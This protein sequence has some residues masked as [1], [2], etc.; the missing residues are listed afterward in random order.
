M[1][2]SKLISSAPIILVLSALLTACSTLGK[3]PDYEH[4]AEQDTMRLETWSQ[5]SSDTNTT[6]PNEL[7]VSPVL[8]SIL[9]QAM[10][11]NP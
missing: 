11:N 4:L 6:Y 2:V 7:L 8:E 1:N 9:G 3:H 5:I 10:E